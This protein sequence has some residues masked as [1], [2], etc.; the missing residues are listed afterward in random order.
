MQEKVQKWLN[1]G[2]DFDEGIALLREIGKDNP[3]LKIISGRPKRYADKVRYLLLKRVNFADTNPIVSKSPKQS[4]S[5]ETY[6]PVFIKT[7]PGDKKKQIPSEI[8]KL[9]KL[10]SK[11]FLERS[12]LHEAM[13]NLPSE[14][15]DSLIEKRSKISDQ[16]EELSFKIDILFE[17]KEQFYKT[18][19]ILTIDEL[20][21][22]KKTPPV[23]QEVLLPSDE[24]GLKKMKKNLQSANTKDQNLLE[25]QSEK[26]GTKPAPM[27][28]G[29]KRLKIELRIDNRKVVITQIDT[30]LVNLVTQNQ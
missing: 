21:P 6:K 8:E 10:H 20:F 24:D 17:A 2:C 9:I 1:D 4:N 26:K 19:E 14:N 30:K 22:E 25:Y 3:T 7:E 5:S 28:N 12:V 13:G 16:I 23:N 11:L 27:P 29:P 18:G 15:T